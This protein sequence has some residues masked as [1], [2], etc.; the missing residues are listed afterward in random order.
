MTDDDKEMVPVNFDAPKEAYEQAKE[1]LEWGQMSEELR[2]RVN[3]IAF[4]AE[5]TRREELRER[6]T[7]LRDDKRK[8]ESKIR[9]FQNE[10]DHIDRKIE[11]IEQQLDSIRDN[12]GEYNGALE[13]LESRLLD[14]E[15]LYQQHEG[16]E[17]VAN[18]AEKPKQEFI[19][20]LQKRN[21]EVPSYAF[22]LSSPHEPTD[23]R[24]VD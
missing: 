1:N 6:L 2:G 9:D 14:G 18:I 17:R 5:T 15:R 8:K 12:E 24:E 19:K 13:M 20:D 3:E 7:S 22:E 21:P 11:R 4:G 23:W 16:L 10:R